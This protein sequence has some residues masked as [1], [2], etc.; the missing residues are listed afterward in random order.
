MKLQFDTN[1]AIA[2]APEVDTAT[3][4]DRD[5]E[6]GLVRFAV[7]DAVQSLEVQ[8]GL[9]YEVSTAYQLSFHSVQLHCVAMIAI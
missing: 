6:D 2:S 8:N 5:Q 9:Q 7:A 3:T 4:H 1:K